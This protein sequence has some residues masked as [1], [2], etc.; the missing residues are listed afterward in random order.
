MNQNA[1]VDAF[2]EKD[3]KWKEEF[4]ALRHI[5]CAA[6]VV[7]EFKWGNPCYTVNGKNVVLIHGFKEYCALL[8]MKG[9]LLTDS[10]GLLVQQTENVQAAR[11]IRFKNL[12]EIESNSEKI[13]SYINQAIEVEKAGLKVEVNLE[14]EKIIPLELQQKFQE[15][16]ELE[17][18]FEKLTPGRQ[19]AYLLYFSQAKQAKTREARIEKY[20]Q[21]ILD[22]KGLK[23]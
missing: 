23:D 20:V 6:Q 15:N 8:F 5:V 9:A 14:T 22:G 2:L 13:L 12:Q 21:P 19:R 17:E 10:D 1:K 11:Q 18:A 16:P 7:E 4:I 3:N